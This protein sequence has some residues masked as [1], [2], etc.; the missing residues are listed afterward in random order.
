MWERHKKVTQPAK[1]ELVLVGSTL[2]LL[3]IQNAHA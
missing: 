3:V 2:T 1:R